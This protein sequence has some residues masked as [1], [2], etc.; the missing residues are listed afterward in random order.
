M[1]TQRRV[2][3]REE[4][5]SLISVLVSIAILGVII[6]PATYLIESGA[7]LNAQGRREVTASNLAQSELQILEA[8]GNQSFQ[9]LVNQLG[10]TRYTRTVGPTAY[11]VTTSIYW[12]QGTT[13]PAG[14]SAN[15][16]SAQ[17]L[18]PTLTATVSVTWANMAPFDPA[19]ATT[20]FHVPVGYTSPGTGAV[21]VVV[22]NQLGDPDQGIPV[23]LTSSSTMSTTTV[24]DAQGCAYF[25]FLAPGSYTVAIASP[26][27]QV[28]T[29]PTGNETPSSTLAVSAGS[30]AQAN[31][32][33]A[34]AATL[35][36]TTPGAS[37]SVPWSLGVSIGSTSLPGGETRYFA[38]PGPL[39]D[40]FPAPSG[41]QAWLGEC[42]LYTSF[43]GTDLGN[44]TAPGPGAT[45]SIALLGQIVNLTVTAN[46]AP[47]AG[48]SVSLTETSSSG[49]PLAG[50]AAGPS[51]AIGTT[52]A[53]GQLSFLAPVGW[54][55]LTVTTPQGQTLTYPSTGAIQASGGAPIDVAIAS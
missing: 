1:A 2:V 43:P 31:F 21:L 38:G 33:Y 16:T 35:D 47:V 34:Q 28:W 7:S 25:P 15:S 32:T 29:D 39:G 18:E 10:T 45:A 23:V 55:T 3:S 41:Y 24:T 5:F 6:A 51:T 37:V 8:Q 17:S 53:S 22:Q 20:A 30:N 26:Q 9:N 42:Y 49:T 48:A 40:I 44:V 46:G 36:L 54:L 50:C 11:T 19:R 4:G 27:G 52:D 14:C 12:T 13:D